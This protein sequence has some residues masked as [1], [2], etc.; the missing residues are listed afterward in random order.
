MFKNS[1]NINQI[2][3]RILPQTIE[4]WHMVLEIQVLTWDRQTKVAGLN[5]YMYFDSKNK[6]LNFNVKTCWL[7]F[8][9]I[10]RCKL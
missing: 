9:I 6:Q 3:N 10:Y 1:T 8:F 4:P 7:P 5:Q 2:N